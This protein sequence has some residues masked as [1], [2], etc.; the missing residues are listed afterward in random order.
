MTSP[1]ARPVLFPG[2][3]GVQQRALP[4]YR[5]PFF[6]ALAQGC[7]G[8]LS[9]FAGMPRSN[10][11]V[12][13]APDLVGA[14]WMRARNRHLFTGRGYLCYQQGL[15]RWLER[16]DP[17]VLVLEANPRYLS[18]PSAI[19]WMHNRQRKVVGWGLGAPGSGSG[20]WRTRVLRRYLASLDG[21]IAYGQVGAL[22]YAALGVPSKRIYVAPNAVAPPPQDW[23]ERPPIEGRPA[24]L[25]YVGR[26]VA[27]KRLDLLIKACGTMQPRPALTIVGDGPARPALQE[28]SRQVFPTAAFAGHQEGEALDRLFRD[29]DLFV[30]PGTGGLAL[31]HAMSHGLPLVA[32]RGDG[33]QADMVTPEN[34]WLLPSEDP[35]ALQAVLQ[36]AL[37]DVTR[38]RRMGKRSFELAR[39]RFNTQAMADAF[40]LALRA[41]MGLD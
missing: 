25:L 26:L 40:L 33:S 18:S 21:L 1:E 11:G 10:E 16:W 41:I 17:D 31:Q 28:L 29:A 24:R 7:A 14:Q 23:N 32:G 3:V 38:L 37:S 4:F 20:G 5:A 27:Q 39:D 22:Q 8:G 36:D 2:R 19:R 15:Q 30:M 35:G 13:S 12:L 6:E 9:V 34:G